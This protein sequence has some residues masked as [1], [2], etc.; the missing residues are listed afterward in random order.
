[1]AKCG[2]ESR[3]FGSPGFSVAVSPLAGPGFAALVSKSYGVPG[4]GVAKASYGI[5]GIA[6][7]PR[8]SGG[9][10]Y[11]PSTFGP[12]H[13]FGETPFSMPVGGLYRRPTR[14]SYGAADIDAQIQAVKDQIDY[15]TYDN[16]SSSKVQSLK[17]QLAALEAQKAAQGGKV[18]WSKIGEGVADFFSNFG[19][20]QEVPVSTGTYA[21]PPPPTPPATPSWVGPAAAAAGVAAVLGIGYLVLKR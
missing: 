15:Y 4:I 8:R 5:P 21:P 12:S 10:G 20:K 9:P 1:M 13:P 7:N 14:V 6:V 17:T 19:K 18:D 3:S 11:L 16:P 2:C